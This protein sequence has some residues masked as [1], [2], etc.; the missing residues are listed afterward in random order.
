MFNYKKLTVLLI[1]VCL[2]VMVFATTTEQ[3]QTAISNGKVTF[4]L[5][6]ETGATGTD[7]ARQKIQDAITKVPESAMIEANRANAA[8]TEFVQKYKLASAPVPLILVFASNGVMAGGNLASKLTTQ[9][10]VAMVPSSKKSEMLKALESGLAVYVT[11]Y[12]SG[13]TNKTDIFKNCAAACNK[14]QGKC[15]AID[16]DMD[17]LNERGLLNQLN[18]N[19][20][21][22]E[23]TT[24]VINAM[25][26]ITDSYTGKVEVDKLISSATKVVSSGCCPPNSGKTCPP[27]PAKKKGN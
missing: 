4:V 8:N 5:V 22:A 25:G 24:V 3:I 2:P 12:R 17:D 1:T 6:T 20:G 7:Q 18:I 13:M 10:L 9:Q 14:M 15:V 11:A 21:S 27:T 19:F 26:Q 23:P 16:V